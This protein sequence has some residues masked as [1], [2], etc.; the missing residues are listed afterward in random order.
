MAGESPK[1]T[2][3]KLVLPKARL[4]AGSLMGPGRS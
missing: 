4:G 1:R 3:G 2:S